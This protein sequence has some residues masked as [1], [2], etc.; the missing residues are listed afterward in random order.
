[1]DLSKIGDESWTIMNNPNNPTGIA[2]TEE[3]S[4]KMA[5]IVKGKKNS[6]ILADEI[7]SELQFD[8]KFKSFRQYLPEQTVISNGISKWA[9]AGGWRLGY[10][11]FPKSLLYLKKQLESVV[12]E[13]YSC[14]SAPI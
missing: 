6:I 11:L 10:C 1:M 2:L 13:T 4:L 14:V 8:G 12:S 9:C 7:Y 5:R 3:E